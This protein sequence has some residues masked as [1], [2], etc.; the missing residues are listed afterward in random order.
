MP[1]EGKA[2]FTT[3]E[4]RWFSTQSSAYGCPHHQVATDGSFSFSPR[5]RREA[6]KKGHD[7]GRLNHSAAQR[8]GN[9]HIAGDDC[10]DQPRHAEQRIAAQLQRI[11]E[12]V[13]HPAQDHI[14]LFQPVDRLEKHAA[15]ADRQI[16]A[17]P[18]A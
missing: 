11:A 12:A 9:L 7:R 8:V 18:P 15:I 17:L 2:G 13:I 14:D 3:T 5:M 10:V 1:R 6:G 4:S 16:G